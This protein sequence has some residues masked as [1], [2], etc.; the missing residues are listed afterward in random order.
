MSINEWYGGTVPAFLLK[1]ML[2]P[3]G[4]EFVSPH[5]HALLQ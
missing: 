1:S 2:I 5:D 3:A 4:R